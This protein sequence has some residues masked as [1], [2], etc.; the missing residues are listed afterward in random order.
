MYMY[1]LIYEKACH[2][3]FESDTCLIWYTL[4]TIRGGPQGLFNCLKSRCSMASRRSC[5]R[6][7][8]RSE[9]RLV[10]MCRMLMTYT[11]LFIYIYIECIFT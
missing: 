5:R 1:V 3:R 8:R 2:R 6:R 10:L 9:M 11:T 7:A 4:A